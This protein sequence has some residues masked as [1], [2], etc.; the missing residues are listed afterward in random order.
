MG[1]EP[2][3][4]KD[5]NIRA[6]GPKYHSDDIIIWSL[7]PDPLGTW[8]HRGGVFDRLCFACGLMG[9]G[10]PYSPQG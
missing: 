5:S 4:S 7:K 2:E 3:G 9:S 10:C 1:P 8:A 6:L